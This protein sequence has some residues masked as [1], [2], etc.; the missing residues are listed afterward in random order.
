MHKKLVK[1]IATPTELKK[2]KKLITVNKL[3]IFDAAKKMNWTYSAVISRCRLYGWKNGRHGGQDMIDKAELK[4]IKELLDKGFSYI[5]IT[6]ELNR[7]FNK[8]YTKSTVTYRAKSRGWKSK[9]MY[10]GDTLRWSNSEVKLLKEL[11]YLDAPIEAYVRRFPGR[12]S[13]AIK[14]KLL[15]LIRDR[16]LKLDKKAIF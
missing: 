5:Q 12:T 8:N 15:G 3:R 9:K 2:L 4:L 10:C 14:H 16:M 6:K 1:H 13:G 7:I 11:F